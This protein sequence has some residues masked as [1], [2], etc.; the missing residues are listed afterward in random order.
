MQTF[1]K[2]SSDPDVILKL[3][4]CIL[5][6]FYFGTDSVSMNFLTFL[7]LLFDYGIN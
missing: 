2:I 4:L 3:S 1:N 6:L 5:Y 7:Q